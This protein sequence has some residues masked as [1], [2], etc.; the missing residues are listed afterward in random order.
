MPP[1]LIPVL[2]LIAKPLGPWNEAPPPGPPSPPF[3]GLPFPARVVTL[4]MSL[5]AG[6]G[7]TLT[8]LLAESVTSTT[9]CS[10]TT[11]QAQPWEK[12]KRA[13]AGGPSAY[14][15][16]P[17]P[18]QVPVLYVRGGMP[19]KSTLRMRWEEKSSTRAVS[20]KRHRPSGNLNWAAAPSPSK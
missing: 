14:P 1:L 16:T 10:R 19:R 5:R 13:E 3:T 11:A 17:P 7:T 4:R 20:S 6:K 2:P 18:A 12:E 15:G 8:R 9:P